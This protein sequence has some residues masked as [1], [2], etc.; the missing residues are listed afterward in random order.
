MKIEKF[1][2]GAGHEKG[3]RAGTENV[4]LIAG[5]GKVKNLLIFV[6]F[7]FKKAFSVQCLVEN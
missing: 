2:H 5:L 6:V 4:A 1:L 3:Y 7:F